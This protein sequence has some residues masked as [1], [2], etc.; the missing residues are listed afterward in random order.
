MARF[1]SSPVS[2]S[3]RPSTR[4]NSTDS[5]FA[6][7]ADLLDKVDVLLREGLTARAVEMLARA[8]SSPWVSN[9]LGV[10]QF[11]L[12]NIP[13]ALGAFRSIAL[14]GNLF[15][16]PDAPMVFKTNYAAALFA[17]DNIDGG[18][19]ILNEIG[20]EQHPAV[21]KLREAVRRWRQS[22]TLWQRINWHM[23]G[24]PNRR[25]ELD[26]PLGDLQ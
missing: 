9:A 13:V 23:G 16:Q 18:L 21:Q 19:R 7:T 11:R 2:T 17:S 22:L 12:G 6:E 14:S 24:R 8:P 4:G 25:L 26:S 20:D 15:L 3:T 10:C 1:K 5:Q